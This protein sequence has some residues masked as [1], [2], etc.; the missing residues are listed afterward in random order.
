VKLPSDVTLADVMRVL[1]QEI[2][3]RQRSLALLRAICA[4]TLKGHNLGR[5]P[6]YGDDDVARVAGL[7]AEGK[8]HRVI[9]D[10]LGMPLASISRLA[11]RGGAKRLGDLRGGPREHGKVNRHRTHVSVQERKAAE[12]QLAQRRRR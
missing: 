2:A 10:L 12:R 8:T 9:A 6:K 5:P 1:E 7:V 3:E 11:T 4:R